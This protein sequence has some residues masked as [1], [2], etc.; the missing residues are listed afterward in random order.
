[1][2]VVIYLDDGIQPYP[3]RDLCRAFSHRIK[4]DLVDIGWVPHKDKSIWEP[5]LLIDLAR[6]P[7]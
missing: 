5:Q 7:L 4:S 6:L 2:Q 1:M 3:V